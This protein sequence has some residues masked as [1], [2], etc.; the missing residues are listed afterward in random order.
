LTYELA[1]NPKYYSL[2]TAKSHLTGEVINRYLHIH[3]SR[4]DLIKRILITRFFTRMIGCT[5]RCVAWDGLN[6]LSIVTY[7]IDK[8][9]KTNY[10]ERFI[11]WLKYVQKEDLCIACAMTDV[12]GDRSL[13]PSQQ[14][15]K[16]MYVHVVEKRED[17]IIVRGAKMHTTG[18]TASHE[19]LVLP[20][21][22]LRAEDKDYAVTFAVPVDAPGLKLIT[23]ATAPRGKREYD[24]PFTSQTGPTE[25][26]TIFDDVFVP[27]DRVFMCGEWEFAGMLVEIFANYH[28]LAATACKSAVASEIFAGIAALLAEYNNVERAEHIQEKLT[29]LVISGEMLFG[30]ATAAA[31]FGEPMG[32]GTYVPNSIYTNVEK[33][34][35][36]KHVYEDIGIVQ[37]IG[38]G[39]IS[40]CPTERDYLNPKTK[41]YI[42]KYL[43]AK[44]N[45]PTE[46]RFRAIKLAEDLTVYGMVGWLTTVTCHGGGSPQAMMVT[47]YRSID[48]QRR[49]QIAKVLA[50]IEPWENSQS[51]NL[52]NMLLA[53]LKVIFYIFTRSAT[54]ITIL[55]S[56]QLKLNSKR[57]FYTEFYLNTLF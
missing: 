48:W 8:K 31:V 29:H 50:R 19:I 27:W 7:E 54:F 57:L 39:A 26:L 55:M 4:E 32:P 30:C 28:R 41:P 14:P 22:A 6:T 21:R 23:R 36:V 2:T 15:D 51:L 18:A 56:V 46:H 13:R 11:N 5:R 38:G 45:V 40:T 35:A 37:D 33:Y 9:Y 3:Q 24:F 53:K 52:Q 16:D 1:H 10:Y 49:K 25:S 42:Y 17:G 43:K 47:L 34:L 20:T 12:K 44:A